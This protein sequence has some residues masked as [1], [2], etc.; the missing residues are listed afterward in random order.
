MLNSNIFEFLDFQ[1]DTNKKVG[2]GRTQ[3]IFCE[4]GKMPKIIIKDFSEGFRTSDH[5]V[6]DGLSY[7]K[8]V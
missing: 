6:F 1:L 5:A 7:K 2:E 3:E 8:V 4:N